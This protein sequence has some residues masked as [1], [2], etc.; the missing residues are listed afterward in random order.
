[1]TSHT[2][3]PKETESDKMTGADIFQL[4]VFILL[5]G[6]LSTVFVMA[7]GLVLKALGTFG[8][9]MCVLMLFCLAKSMLSSLLTR[10]TQSEEN[11]SKLTGISYNNFRDCAFDGAS[12][13]DLVVVDAPVYSEEAYQKLQRDANRLNS[14]RPAV[15]PA[16]RTSRRA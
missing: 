10:N 2:M 6:S 7:G 13:R 5:V 16:P 4:S 14:G 12:H 3:Q 1:M 11:A 15:I 9:T 8:L